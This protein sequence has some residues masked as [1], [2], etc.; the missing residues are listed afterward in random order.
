MNTKQEFT[1]EEIEHRVKENNEL[2]SCYLACAGHFPEELEESF[3][4]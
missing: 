4:W 2:Y 1:Q 3:Y